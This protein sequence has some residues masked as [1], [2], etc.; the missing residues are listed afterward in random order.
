[1][2]TTNTFVRYFGLDGCEI[3]V[4]IADLQYAGAPIDPESGAELEYS[5]DLFSFD[6]KNHKKID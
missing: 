6:G 3:Y 2:N 5:R 1:M 4:S